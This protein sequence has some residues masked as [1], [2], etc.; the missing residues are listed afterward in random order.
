MNEQFYSVI[1]QIFDR[2]MRYKEEA[3]LF[4]MESL[5]YTQRKFKRHKHV[6]GSE[7]LEG[8]RELLLNKF[9]PMTLIVLQHWGIHSTEDFGHIVFRLVENKVLSKTEDDNVETF[10]DAYDFQ[11]AFENDYR[12]QLAKKISRMRSM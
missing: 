11:E 12:R 4:V 3:Y 9:G 6:T 7:L 5:S 10:K 8:I 1:E 2:D